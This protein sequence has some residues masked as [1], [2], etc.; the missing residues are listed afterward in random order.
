MNLLSNLIETNS[1][2]AD[3]TDALPHDIMKEI[4]KNIRGGAQ[5]LNLKWANAL[6]LVHKAYKVSNVQRP[7]PEM[8]NA[9]KQYEENLQ[10]AVQQLAKFRGMKADWRMSSSVFIEAVN[11]NSYIVTIED[12]GHSEK[13]RVT[14]VDIKD[15]VEKLKGTFKDY[16]VSVRKTPQGVLLIPYQYG[17]KQSFR[18][19]IQDIKLS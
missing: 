17:V 3:M 10:F 9:W 11:P 16:E 19:R 4:Q 6:E 1:Y 2:S 8:K 7:L 12:A 13:Y 14:G 15:V 5:D 18:V